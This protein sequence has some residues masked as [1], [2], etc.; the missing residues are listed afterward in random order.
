MY[1]KEIIMST[2]NICF[3]G[4]IRKILCGYHLLFIAKNV[5]LNRGSLVYPAHSSEAPR[6][7]PFTKC[8]IPSLANTLIFFAEEM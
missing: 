5:D 8:T 4:K 6:Q 1:V 3:H 2:Y 7:N